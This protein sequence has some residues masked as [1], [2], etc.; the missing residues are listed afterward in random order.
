MGSRAPGPRGLDLLPA[1]AARP[2]PHPAD[3]GPARPHRRAGPAGG[4][5]D[6][7]GG[8]A[9]RHRH[10]QLRVHE[11]HRRVALALRAGAAGRPRA[12]RS[13]GRRRR[14]DGDRGGRA[15]QGAGPLHPR[16]RPGLRG[17]PLDGGARP[18]QP[19]AGGSPHRACAGRTRPA[20][21]DPRLHRRGA[22]RRDQGP[23]GRRPGAL[24][25][26]RAPLPQRGHHEP[27]G[28]PE[29]LRGVQLAG[30]LL[31]GQFL[32][33]AADPVAQADPRRRGPRRAHA[34]P[35]P[36]GAAGD[37]GAVQ[38]AARRRAQAQARRV[39]RSRRRQ[40]RLR[41]HAAA[42]DDLGPA[43]QPREFVPREGTED[44]SAGAA[45]GAQARRLPGRHGGLRR[46]G[47]GQRE[48]AEAGQRPLRPR[49]YRTRGRAAR[50]ARPSRQ[51]HHHGLGPLASD[52]AADRLRQ[53]DDGGRDARPAA[54]G[55][56]DPGG[57]GGRA[58]DLRPR[59]AR[60]QGPLLRVRSLPQRLPAAG[61]L[62]AHALQGAPLAAPGRARPGEPA[63][64]GGP[65][66]PAAGGARRDHR[67]RAHSRP[68]AAC[69]RRSTAVW[70]ASPTPTRSGSTRW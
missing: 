52:H 44:R 24:D 15:A 28:P 23:G 63:A 29:L 55:R 13:S 36:A 64:A 49:Q 31:G 37:H 21:G 16:A 5:R 58:P 30:L 38:R 68:D 35:R 7:A 59:R 12:A 19:P 4:E 26:H 43:G 8:E 3:P 57:G 61:G 11:G 27:R 32:G 34:H 48:S 70:P 56:E 10:G 6:G 2:A 42:P 40:Y 67:D 60:S 14:G 65:A 1:A 18:S 54:R 45:R 50:G 20:R 47:G 25:R 51:S 9:R 39:G 41:G 53:G 66:D 62:P 17:D 69:G 33:R 22:S 46:R